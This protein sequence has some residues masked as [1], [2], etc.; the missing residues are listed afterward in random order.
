MFLI[1]ILSLILGVFKVGPLGQVF[2][3]STFELRLRG[4]W[5]IA[6][7]LGLNYPFFGVGH[8]QFVNYFPRMFG[9]DYRVKFGQVVTD[10]AH[11]HFL[12]IFAESGALALFAYMAFFLFTAILIF[13]LFSSN[14]NI[15]KHLALAILGVWIGFI[16]Q[17]LVSID[18]MGVSVWIWILSG[19]LLGFTRESQNIMAGKSSQRKLISKEHKEVHASLF[20]PNVKVAIL[21]SALV[22]TLFAQLAL[23]DNRIW[24]LEN[25]R[26]QGVSMTITPLDLETLNTRSRFLPIDP[27]LLA[28]SSSLLLSYGRTED[29]FSLLNRAIISNPESS[30]ALN[31][32]ATAIETI[33]N[34]SMA[35]AT[36]AREIQV[37]PWNPNS[38]IEYIRDLLEQKN[39]IAAKSELDRLQT[40][41]DRDSIEIAK[42]Y[43][44]I[45]GIG[46]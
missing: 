1:G 21:T 31:L 10:N 28:R 44:E 26:K 6:S 13:K 36:R 23:L 2:S 16:G 41:A 39:F 15:E 3:K 38:S 12:H 33:V 42:R 11:N 37:D 7:E 14:A 35:V 24:V 32:K 30:S 19:L 4:Y 17:M 45:V 5:P 25:A 8:E 9:P 20:K 40:F 43:F 22:F 34:R 27:I 29:G 18:T 46:L